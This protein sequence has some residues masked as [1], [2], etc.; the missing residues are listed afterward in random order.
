M[1]ASLSLLWAERRGRSQP[2]SLQAAREVP[3]DHLAVCSPG[4][5][6]PWQKVAAYHGSPASWLRNT[7]LS[8]FGTYFNKI[9]F[10]FCLVYYS[11]C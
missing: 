3:S 2:P 10:V 11:T 8:I 9:A 5:Q 1:V 4:L 7:A 6:H